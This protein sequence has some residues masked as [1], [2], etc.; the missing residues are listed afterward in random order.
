MKYKLGKN[1]AKTKLACSDCQMIIKKGEEFH[2][3]QTNQN[4]HLT[5]LEKRAGSLRKQTEAL[6]K[7][8]FGH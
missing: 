1:I 6:N 3:T 8:F 4:L 5:C 7:F 2:R